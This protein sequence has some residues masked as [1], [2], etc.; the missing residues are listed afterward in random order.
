MAVSSLDPGLTQKAGRR[1]AGEDDGPSPDVKFTHVTSQGLP[2]C[3]VTICWCVE[4]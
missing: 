2:S 3:L 1:P 4:T